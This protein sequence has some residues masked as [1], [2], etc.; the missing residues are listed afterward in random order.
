MAAAAVK[1]LGPAGP[2]RWFALQRV[3]CYCR[4]S[5]FIPIENTMPQKLTRAQIKAGLEQVPIESLLSSGEGKQPKITGKMKAFAHAVALGQSKASAYR[6][7]HKAKPAASTITTEP[8]KLMRDP[9]IAREVE[10]YKL[11]IEAEK[12][13]T[14]AQLKALLV[15]QLVEHSLDDDFP[16]A[17]RMKALQLIGN[18]FEVGAF[19]ERKES[20]VVHKSSDIRARLLDRLQARSP[21]SAPADALELLQEI[22]DGAANPDGGSGAPTGGAPASEGLPP[23]CA[24]T[25]TVSLIQSPLNSDGVGVSK[26]PEQVLDFDKQ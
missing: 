13:R 5:Y 7:S 12:H 3:F 19:L 14:P 4:G 23:P 20:V 6:V 18:L 26:N 16:P 15:Q 22:R 24:P 25:H 2:V 11:A 1:A 21:A 10:A 8:Y 17:Q 9:R